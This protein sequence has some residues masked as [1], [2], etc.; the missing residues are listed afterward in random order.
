MNEPD[1]LT[2]VI[3]GGIIGLLIGALLCVAIAL[4]TILRNRT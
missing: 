4:V 3:A 1:P 2:Y